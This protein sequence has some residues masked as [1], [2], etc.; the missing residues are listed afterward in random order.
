MSRVEVIRPPA[1]SSSTITAA[2]PARSASW[3]ASAMSSA[4]TG[5]MADFTFTTSTSEA[6]AAGAAGT[7]LLTSGAR[8]ASRVRTR[9]GTAAE[10]REGGWE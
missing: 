9:I 10:R 4:D 8:S 1:V 7:A 6:R 3:M 2:A 5:W